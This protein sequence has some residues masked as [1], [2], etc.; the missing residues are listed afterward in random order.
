MP[1][2][3]E[4][5]IRRAHSVYKAAVSPLL[6]P[7][8]R[9]LPT[10]STYACE[11]LIAHAPVSCWSNGVFCIPWGSLSLLDDREVAY[12]FASEADLAGAHPIWNFA[13]PTAR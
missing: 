13:A 11:A 8:C 5:L 6:G 12:S 10:C 3:Y 7:A 4:Q 2:A 9:F 1:G